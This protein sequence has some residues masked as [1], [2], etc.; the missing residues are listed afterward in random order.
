MLGDY[1]IDIAVTNSLPQTALENAARVLAMNN[2]DIMRSHLDVLSDGN[3]GNVTMLRLLVSSIDKDKPLHDEILDQMKEEL[4]RTKWMD[5]ITMDLVFTKYPWLGVIKGEIIT[6]MCCLL[7]PIMAPTN[8]YAFSRS[9]I[10]ET[11]MKD[12]YIRYASDI[13]ELFLDRFNP[14]DPIR[15]DEFSMR[16]E[17]LLKQIGSDVEDSLAKE[18]LA[19]MLDIVSHTFRTNVYLQ[20]R[21][22]LGLR[23]DPRVMHTQESQTRDVPY[24]VFF[25]HGRR[26]NAFHCRFRDISRGGMRIVTPANSELH[27]LESSR[28]YEECWGLAFAQ[29]LKNKDI[30]EGG[31]KAVV[32][33]QCDDLTSEAKQFIMRKSVKAFTNTLLDLILENEETKSHIVDR[34]GK[35]EVLYLG[36]DEQV[37]VDDI[38]WIVKRAKLRGYDN[39]NALMSSKP[40]AGINHKEYGVTSEGV[41]CFLDEALQRVLSINPKKDRFSLKLTGGPGGDVAGNMIKLSIRDYGRNVSF[42]GIADE[43]GCAEDPDGLDHEELLRL[44]DMGLTISHFDPTKLGPDGSIHLVD[45]EAGIK[46]RNS[47]HNRLKAD[48][49]V[50]CGGRPNTIDISNYKAFLSANGEPSSKLIVEGANLFITKEARKAL[51]DEAGVTIIKDSSANKCGVITSSYEICAAMMLSEEEFYEQK[52]TIVNEVL[53]KLRS[54]ARLEAELLFREFESEPGKSHVSKRCIIYVTFIVDKR[55]LLTTILSRLHAGYKSTY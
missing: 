19:K 40:R 55:L 4:K 16:K 21:Y 8:Q 20:N 42:V 30:P 14:N 9:N 23:L 31:S 12:R 38:D 44:V 1:W 54:L 32:L 36:P 28:Q 50:P 25:C 11:I 6:A 5:P 48:A 7:H 10:F 29:H 45:N 52:D 22:A 53:E 41:N 17:K 35:K 18:L 47:M 26:F 3:N 24:G 33:I 34:L 2:L 46:H 15:D 49:F 13:A 27:A 39:P 51:Y 37:T 43:S